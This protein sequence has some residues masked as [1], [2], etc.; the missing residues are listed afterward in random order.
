[1][2]LWAAALPDFSAEVC[3]VRPTWRQG[4]AEFSAAPAHGERRWRHR[5]EIPLG[6][7]L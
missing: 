5:A 1:M 4:R 6:S 3:R 2:N 7:S